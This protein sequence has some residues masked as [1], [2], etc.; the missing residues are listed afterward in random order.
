MKS[1]LFFFLL[2]F[3]TLCAVTRVN[4]AEELIYTV[5]PGD[6]LWKLASI[7]LKGI[8]YYRRLQQY[9]SVRQPLRMKPGTRLKIPVS[10]LKH[11]PA[12][13]LVVSVMGTVELTSGPDM[14]IIQPKAGDKLTAGDKINTGVDGS[15]TI[16]FA[17]GSQIVIK[18]ETELL[19]D[20]LSAYGNGSMIDTRLRMQHGRMDTDV[21]TIREGSSHYEI[22]TPAAVSIVRGT[23]FRISAENDR[24]VSRVEV[25]QGAVDVSAASVTRNV[26]AGY[27]TMAEAGKPPSEPRQLLPALDIS[28]WPQQVQYLPVTLT[29]LPLNGAVAYRMQI[30]EAADNALQLIDRILTA[31]QYELPIFPDGRYILQLRAIDDMGLEGLNAVQE[32][33]LEV[34]P[35]APVIVMPGREKSGIRFEWQAVDKSSTY[36][37]Q[38][39]S[40]SDFSILGKELETKETNIVLPSLAAGTYFYRV[41]AIDTNGYSGPYSEVGR[42]IHAP[43]LN[44]PLILG[45]F[46]PLVL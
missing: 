6:N 34:P 13:A 44:W 32:M 23:N 7:H 29:W 9:N 5:R 37:F 3:L 24:P 41:R 19:M 45:V 16:S 11:A 43:E 25:L 21:R 31:N 42:Y 46:L 15:L 2:I 30:S 18:P 14:T 35:I 8:H 4:A 33:N 17:D 27:G 28:H 1:F 36:K 12:R 22:T 20:A 26:P 10:W 40:E 39:S 38:L